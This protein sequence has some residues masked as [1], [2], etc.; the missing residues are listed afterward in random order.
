MAPP[1]FPVL[2]RSDADAEK[3]RKLVLRESI[4]RANGGYVGLF[5]GETLSTVHSGLWHPLVSVRQIV[6]E[7]SLLGR[8]TDP[9]GNM[10]EEVRAPYPGEVLSIVG[11]PPVNAGEAVVFIGRL[12]DN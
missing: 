3:G 4:L 7:G 1:L 2:E 8:L 5:K 11:P 12:P 6:E 9:F 10:L